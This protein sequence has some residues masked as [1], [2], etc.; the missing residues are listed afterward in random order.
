MSISTSTSTSNLDPDL[1]IDLDVDLDL[2]VGL[3]LYLDLDLDLNLDFNLDLDLDLD[4]YLDELRRS[5]GRSQQLT[6]MVFSSVAQVVATS[7]SPIKPSPVPKEETS[8]PRAST[9]ACW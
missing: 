7:F 9:A 6:H 1:D 3:D 8:T 4:L 2:D 5:D